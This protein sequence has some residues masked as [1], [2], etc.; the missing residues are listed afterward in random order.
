MDCYDIAI[1]GLPAGVNVRKFQLQIQKQ[2]GDGI[3]EKA[4][5]TEDGKALV[6]GVMFQDKVIAVTEVGIKAL[7]AG[8]QK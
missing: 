6:A 4:E 7:L 8:E 3:I 2:I 1:D 5:K